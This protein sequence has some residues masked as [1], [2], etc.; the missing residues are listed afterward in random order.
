MNHEGTTT[1][2]LTHEP[3][4]PDDA[5]ELRVR[6]LTA[7]DAVVKPAEEGHDDLVMSESLTDHTRLVLMRTVNDRGPYWSIAVNPTARFAVSAAGDA[8]APK[9]AIYEVP[10]HG[11]QLR[12]DTAEVARIDSDKTRVITKTEGEQLLHRVEELR[13]LLLHRQGRLKSLSDT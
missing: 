6:L 8:D 9:L 5:H 13:D 2:T 7:F 1:D 4:D 12:N 10:D 3:L 11:Y